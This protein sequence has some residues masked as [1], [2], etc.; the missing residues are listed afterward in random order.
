M[1]PAEQSAIAGVH[2]VAT[3]T[4]PRT[5]V[6]LHGFADNLATWTRLVG[7][8]AVNARVVAIDLPGHGRSRRRFST[9]LL[10]GYAD[11]VREVLDAEGITDPVALIGN[12]MGAAVAT[13][14]GAVY[15]ERT[16]RVVLIDMPGLGGVPKLWRMAFSRPVEFGLRAGI[17]VAGRRS[18]DVA[19]WGLGA[20]YRCIAAAD[21]RRI[22]SLA[23]ADF[24]QPYARRG[25]VPD[26]LPIG[27]ALCAD[28]AT[29]GLAT[30]VSALDAP[31]LLVFGSRDVLTPARVLRRIGRDGGA[32]VIPG[33]GHCPQLDQPA[34]L[35]EQVLPFLG[36]ERAGRTSRAA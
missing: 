19:Q 36:V 31:V 27:R 16:E 14:F 2:Y 15:P 4:G 29:A 22:D 3:G 12:S 11:V 5:I 33:C 8:L 13:V 32:V 28:L 23:R 35:L 1:P 34:L 10:T 30:A 25:S 20:F 21:P 17:G 26:L 9:P 24:A 18:S 6:L 7:P